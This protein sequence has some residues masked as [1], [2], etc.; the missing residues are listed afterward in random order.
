MELHA[1][2][3]SALFSLVSTFRCP[4][5]LKDT[6]VNL[7][8][9]VQCPLYLFIQLV[10]VVIES[11]ILFPGKVEVRESEGQSKVLILMLSSC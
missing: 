3:R 10:A 9:A 2:K 4:L 11:I 6:S 5:L 8:T 1:G 7:I